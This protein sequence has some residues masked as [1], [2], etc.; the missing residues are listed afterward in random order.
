MYGRT[1]CAGVVCSVSTLAGKRLMCWR[2]PKYV[3]GFNLCRV[4][5]AYHKQPRLPKGTHSVPYHD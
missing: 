5:C 2:S 3:L 1:K 4:R